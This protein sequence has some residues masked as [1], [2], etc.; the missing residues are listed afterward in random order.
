MLARTL[1]QSFHKVIMGF[2]VRLLVTIHLCKYFV[3]SVRKVETSN[4]HSGVNHFDQ[5]IHV[6]AS[7]SESAHNLGISVLERTIG[8]NSIKARYESHSDRCTL[9]CSQCKTLDCSIKKNWIEF[10][11]YQLTLIIIAIA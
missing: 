5:S 7:R 6:P 4:I 11:R 8:K 2:S 9:S 10:G 1:L 3:R